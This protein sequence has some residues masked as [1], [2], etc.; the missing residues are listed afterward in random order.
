MRMS[1]GS[2]HAHALDVKCQMDCMLRVHLVNVSHPY[3]DSFFERKRAWM[4]F[5]SICDIFL[6]RINFKLPTRNR[7]ML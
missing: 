4:R 7:D 3:L 5:T 6:E 1:T 2:T